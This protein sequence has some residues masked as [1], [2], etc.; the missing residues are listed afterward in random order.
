MM[1]VLLVCILSISQS[2]VS[3]FSKLLGDIELIFSMRVCS[4]LLIFDK[5]M[6]IG[7]KRLQIFSQ[8]LDASKP[9]Q[10]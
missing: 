7:P 8:Y 5:I 6:P 2:P 10:V 1:F 3:L 9:D 4:S